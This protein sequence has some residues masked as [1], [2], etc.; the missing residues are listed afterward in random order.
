MSTQE[1]NRPP[2]VGGTSTYGLYMYVPRNRV[3]FARFSVLILNRV[4]IFAPFG[5]V[6]PV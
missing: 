5:I 6:P 4:S 3:W 2:G 1:M